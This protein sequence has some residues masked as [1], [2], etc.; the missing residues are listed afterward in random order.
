MKHNCLLT[1]VNETSKRF[2]RKLRF[3]YMSV[4]C[5]VR[6]WATQFQGVLLQIS[7]QTTAIDSTAKW[8]TRW[9]VEESS[10]IGR[11]R[12][13]MVLADLDL[14][15]SSRCFCKVMTIKRIPLVAFPVPFTILNASARKRQNSVPNRYPEGENLPVCCVRRY[16]EDEESDDND[17]VRV[18]KLTFS[19]SLL[20]KS[21]VYAKA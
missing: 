16:L 5:S 12:K 15:V 4:S 3:V 8:R 19:I 1:F 21:L 20:L 9:W 6:R 2:Q 14:I 11:S 17:V 13:A 10:E 18:Y 7:I